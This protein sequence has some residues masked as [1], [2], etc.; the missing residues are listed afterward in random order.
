MS[1]WNDFIGDSSFL[2]TGWSFPVS[3]VDG[4]RKLEVSS[5]DN[6]VHDSLQVLLTT[7][8]FERVTRPY[9]GCGLS[10]FIYGDLSSGLLSHI[11]DKVVNA[12]LMFEPRITLIDVRT[13][14]DRV[15]FNR[16]LITLEYIVRSTNARSNFVYPFYIKE[17]SNY[18]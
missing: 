10:K 14:I 8:V 17:M 1:K 9:F 15:D 13:V 4:G 12:V 18:E 11:K 3:F 6:N 2:G 7:E 5:G 16:L